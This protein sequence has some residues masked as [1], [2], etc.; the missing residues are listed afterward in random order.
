MGKRQPRLEGELQTA[1]RRNGPLP[2]ILQHAGRGPFLRTAAAK[3]RISSGR[4]R[5]RQ[6]VDHDSK[7]RSLLRHEARF[8]AAS[9]LSERSVAVVNQI[10]GYS[11]TGT[12]FESMM[13]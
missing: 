4:R 6:A 5:K 2:P 13:R 3:L 9:Q 1:R 8:A 12:S 11:T 7:G 10:S